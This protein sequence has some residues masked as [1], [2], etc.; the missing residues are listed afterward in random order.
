MPEDEPRRAIVD[1]EGAVA[2]QLPFAR[3]VVWG[4]LEKAGVIPDEGAREGI[5]DLIR[6]VVVRGVNAGVQAALAAT[7]EALAGDIAIE[8]ERLPPGV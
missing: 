7:R 2:H 3:A 6:Q 1:V 8:D 4:V 5:D